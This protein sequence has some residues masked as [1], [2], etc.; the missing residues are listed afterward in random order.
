[1]TLDP[2]LNFDAANRAPRRAQPIGDIPAADRDILRRLAE[3]KMQIGSLPIQQE[4][5]ALWTRLNRL[6]PVK[7]L[8]WINEIPWHEMNW[9]DEL[10]PRCQHPFARA[11]EM[12]LRLE[13][14]QWDHLPGDM[15]VLPMIHSPLAIH[16]SGFGIDE[17]VSIVRTD[18][19]SSVVS[20]HFNRQI[21]DE[22]DIE[23]IQTPVITHDAGASEERYQTLVALLGDI[24]PVRKR[25]MPGFWF[26]PWDELI[27]WWTVEGA[28]VDLADRPELVQ[29]AMERLVAAYLA[30][31][32]QYERLNL[33]ALNNDNTRVGSGGYGCTDELPAPGAHPTHVRAR[34]EWG[35]ATAQIFSSVSPRMHQRFALQYERRWLERFGLTYYGCCEPLDIKMGILRE[36]PNLRKVSMSPWVDLQ[37]AVREVGQDYVFSRKPNP[38]LFAE[39]VFNLEKARAEL[40][41]A[42]DATQDCRVEVILKDI[43]T[44]RYEPQRLWQWAAMASE[45]TARYA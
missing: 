45:E 4:R 16:D 37:R 32:D 24:I 23:R 17:S 40:R 8:V 11:L 10:T 33:L 7:P 3:R 34:D 26:A 38:A 39:D 19:A 18:D 29:A 31:L 1:M 22:Q 35:C 9:N 28:M 36:V 43:S 14:Y 21:W 27:R 41:E 44:V 20:R 25:G 15:I 6:E 13:L 30:R 2:T 5:H 42:L 12:G